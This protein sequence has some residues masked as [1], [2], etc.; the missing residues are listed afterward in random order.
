MAC[1]P[2][3]YS[4]SDGNIQCTACEPGKW[5]DH[6]RATMCSSA[7]PGTYAV[8]GATFYEHCPAGTFNPIFGASRISSC[9]LCPPG[10]AT[11][12]PGRSSL[13]DCQSC[14]PGTHAHANGTAICTQ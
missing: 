13:D 5:M 11:P 3:T 1:G 7:Q 10:K 4:A 9:L 8:R 6:T 2:G 12:I 14:F